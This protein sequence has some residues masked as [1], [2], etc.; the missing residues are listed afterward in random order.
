V[1][2]L[3]RN[4]VTLYGVWQHEVPQEFAV[5]ALM[6]DD[7]LNNS[8]NSA[9]YKVPA[10]QLPDIPIMGFGA[11]VLRFWAAVAALSGGFLWINCGNIWE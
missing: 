5:S 7:M 6:A 10:M 8:Q 11:L 3:S 1:L 2:G 9:I 4:F